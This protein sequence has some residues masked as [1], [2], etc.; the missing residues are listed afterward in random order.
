MN[1]FIKFGFLLG[2]VAV[3]GSCASDG[4]R[5]YQY[6]PNMYR[7]IGYETYQ[8]VAFLPST[9][10]AM[11]PAEGSIAR[12]YM[13]YKFSSSPEDRILAKLEKSPLDSLDVEK[14]LKVGK[15]MYNIYCAVCHG[16]KG[17]GKGI[18]VER[19]KILGVPTYGDAGRDI[20]VG[21][22]YHTIY[23]GLN[24]MGSYAN[25]LSPK[26]RWQVAEYVVTLKDKL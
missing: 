25:Q 13:P 19:D 15:E 16:S 2:L 4:S 5:N 9:M 17:D 20:T 23:Y 1:K 22:T 8:E 7:S 11:I 24:S 6:F 26:E 14:N 21:G 10:E 12:G 18:L 3:L